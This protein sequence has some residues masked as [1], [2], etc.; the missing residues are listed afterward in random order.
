MEGLLCVV[1]GQNPGPYTLAKRS[2]I[3]LHSQLVLV[4]EGGW[5]FETGS[6]CVALATLEFTL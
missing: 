6:I 1:W 4:L 3:E 2:T 5:F